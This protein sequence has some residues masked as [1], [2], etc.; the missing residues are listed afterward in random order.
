MVVK[1]WKIRI[2]SDGRPAI[3]FPS[4]RQDGVLLPKADD[5]ELSDSFERIETC[6]VCV[7]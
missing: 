5:I 6:Q 2:Q 7:H 1:D 3:T 4:G